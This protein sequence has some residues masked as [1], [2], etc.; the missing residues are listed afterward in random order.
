[1]AK[2]LDQAG[3]NYLW[4]KIRLAFAD[5]GHLHTGKYIEGNLT[6][7]TAAAASN[8]V[9][10]W[11]TDGNTIGVGHVL[12]RDVSST[13]TFVDEV[14]FKIGGGTGTD[15][16][17]VISPVNKVYKIP[18][19]AKDR[20]G[21]VK[22]DSTV[23]SVEGLIGSTATGYRST[24]IVNGIPYYVHYIHPSYSPTGTTSEQNMA[25]DQNFTVLDS[26]NVDGTG[27]VIGFNTKIVKVPGIVTTTGTLNNNKIVL[28]AGDKGV[29]GTSF[30][31]GGDTIGA[32]ASRSTTLATEQAVTN[33]LS[34]LPILG[35][36]GPI[37]GVRN[38][39]LNTTLG[40]RITQ[41]GATSGS[42]DRS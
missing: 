11:K 13:N 18:Y 32:T 6:G 7:S 14:T 23:T 38:Q 2:Y 26:V 1:M 37:L 39:V 9:A 17:V 25:H 8:H 5:I 16:G 31:L 24:P 21:V 36:T 28:G 35:A 12:D 3:L 20:I 10:I 34:Q 40:I 15:D 29:T 33:A 41:G 19:A 42:S 4:Q 27:H 30:S 22:T